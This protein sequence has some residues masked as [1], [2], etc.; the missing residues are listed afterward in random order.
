LA[1]HQTQIVAA[2]L[3]PSG[4]N[5]EDRASAEYVA[6]G[7]LLAWFPEQSKPLGQASVFV[8]LLVIM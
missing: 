1:T 8:I 3:S 5:T 6:G 4:T 2:R 7:D